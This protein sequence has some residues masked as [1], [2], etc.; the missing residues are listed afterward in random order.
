MGKSNIA[1]RQ[2]LSHKERF[3]NFVNGALFQGTPVFTAE[4]L[5][6]E[7]GH[8]G[9]ILKTTDEKEIT[10]ERYRDITMTARTISDETKI[11]VLAC[12]NQDEI[13]YAMPVR[14]MLYDALNYAEQVND[15][16]RQRRNDKTLSSSAEFLSGLKK[17]DRLCPVITIVFYYGEEKWDGVRDLHELL[18]V[19]RDEYAI[20]RSFIPNYTINLIDPR[21]IDDL[22]CF[23]EDLQTVFKM[24]QYRKDKQ[25]LLDYVKE[26]KDF[27]EDVD[28]DTGHAIE[29]FLGSQ[30]LIGNM[31]K[32]EL[33]GL[34]MCQALEEYYQD[35]I[36][37]GIERGFERGIEH[38]IERGIE[39]GTIQLVRKK[40][41]Q[42][43]SVNEITE[44]MELEKSSVLLIKSLTE[45]YPAESDA[46]IT[47][48][49]TALQ[50]EKVQV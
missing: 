40:L 24:L 42:G 17:S 11:I 14:N 19:D 8:Q 36:N 6:K 18:G 22:N 7:D 26:N 41:N 47:D 15:I 46:Q 2:W 35:G 44:W 1:I 30:S 27:F 49:F 5:K 28:E 25:K 45:E 23:G 29:V 10:I 43:V 33:G 4:N 16:R 31:K 50:K 3:S 39:R 21:E 32:N 38:G 13:H 34:N 9:L 20:L 12:E 48:R 37:E